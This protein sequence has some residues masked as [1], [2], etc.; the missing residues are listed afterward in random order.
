MCC[1]IAFE[2]RG[3]HR[4]ISLF[5]VSRFA[6][7][8]RPS[9]RATTS[10]FTRPPDALSTAPTMREWSTRLVCT[11]S[12]PPLSS[13]P[14]ADAIASAATCVCTRWGGSRR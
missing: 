1:T 6:I 13:S 9:T 8:S 10:R 5:S 7:A 2:P 14:F 4:S 3:M 11:A 12:F